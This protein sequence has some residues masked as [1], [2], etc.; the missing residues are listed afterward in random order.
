MP[1]SHLRDRRILVLSVGSAAAPTAIRVLASA[2]ADVF[3]GD[4]SL[5]SEGLYLVPESN[6]VHHAPLESVEAIPEL[7]RECRRLEIELIVPTASEGFLNLAAARRLFAVNGV[8]VLVP[9][10]HAAM[11]ALDR[12]EFTREIEGRFPMPRTYIGEALRR[13]IASPLPLEIE[14]REPES[15]IARQRITSSVVPIEPAGWDALIGRR[16][17]PGPELHVLTFR[18]STAVPS[19]SIAIEVINKFG[20]V[21]EVFAYRV[22]L[23]PVAIQL[24]EDVVEALELDGLASVRIVKGPCDRPEVVSIDPFAHPAHRLAAM[25]GRNLLVAS[26]TNALGIDF[27]LSEEPPLELTSV[28]IIDELLVP[29]DAAFAL[30]GQRTSELGGAAIETSPNI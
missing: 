26:A 27:Q 18:P 24:A 8:R 30:G 23:D 7:I 1:H 6:R 13:A 29:S 5:H 19:A 17:L 28:Q 16:I 9:S 20:H 25:A 10:V 14:G 15:Q 11:L 2:G 21:D 22:V 4:A 12:Y 3:A